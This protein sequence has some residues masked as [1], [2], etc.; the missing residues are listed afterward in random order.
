VILLV[1]LAKAFESISDV[2]FGLIQ[3]NER[4]DRIAMS[5][6]I[7]GSLSL[8]LLGMGV[9]ISHSLIWG[10]V[11]LVCAWAIVLVGYDFR[12]GS[13]ILTQMSQLQ[14]RWHF[15]TLVKL[16]WLSLPLGFT[17]MLWS[18]NSNIPRYFIEHYLGEH[19]LGIFA[20][21]SYLIVAGRIVIKAVGSSAIPRLAKYYAAADVIAFRALLFKLLGI[22]V[23]MGATVVLVALVAGKEVLTILYKPEYAQYT[24][25]FVWLMVAAGFDYIFSSLNRGMMASRYFR[26]QL[27]LITLVSTT[28]A[29]ISLLL[30]PTQGMQGAAIAMIVG[31]LIGIGCSTGVLFHA[32]HKLDSTVN[33]EESEV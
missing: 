32:L 16:G 3:Q 2:F 20:A 12:S 9:Y 14:P 17:E 24:D 26:I 18:L 15:K 11:G 29:I 5:L 25:L 31:I 33:Q 21:I 19:K 13:L 30:V 10:V 6:M 8:F 22:S 23:L 1:G 4:M 28:S 7:K 27:P